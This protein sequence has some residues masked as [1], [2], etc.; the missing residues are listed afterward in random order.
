MIKKLR[1]YL[2]KIDSN[3]QKYVDLFYIIRENE[4]N[5]QFCS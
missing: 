3:N 2:F 5:F 1:N 4:T